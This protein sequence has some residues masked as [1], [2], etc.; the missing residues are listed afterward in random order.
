MFV[1]FLKACVANPSQ[2]RN[3]YKTFETVLPATVS[4]GATLLNIF[5]Q[6]M[7]AL[8]YVNGLVLKRGGAKKNVFEYMNKMGICVSYVH[9][10]NLQDKIAKTTYDEFSKLR[11]PMIV[12]DNVDLRTHVRHMTSSRYFSLPYENFQE[13]YVFHRKVHVEMYNT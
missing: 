9:V 5:N 2:S 10:L 7:S 1:Q 11:H 3:K 12:G 6:E 8:Q 13:S 4:A